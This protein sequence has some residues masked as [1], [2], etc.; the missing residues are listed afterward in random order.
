MNEARKGVDPRGIPEE[1]WWCLGEVSVVF[2][3]RQTNKILENER[4]P[5]EW[6]RR[7][8][9]SMFKNKGDVQSCSN[10]KGINLIRRSI[11][12]LERGGS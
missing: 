2:S 1:A 4:M 5:E 3:T 11:K 7:V 9:I 8:V 12:L 6:S 10:H